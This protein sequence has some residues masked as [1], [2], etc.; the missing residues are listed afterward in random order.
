M[1]NFIFLS[2]FFLISCT[3]NINITLEHVMGKTV[4]DAVDNTEK[5]ESTVTAKTQAKLS[6][7]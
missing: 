1:R 3:Q 5:T 2:C 6:G 4:K 7:L